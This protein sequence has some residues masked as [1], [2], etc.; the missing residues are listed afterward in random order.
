MND[1]LAPVALFVYNRPEHTLKTLQKLSEADFSQETRLYI[2]ADGAKENATEEQKNR[3]ARVR[4]IIRQKQWCG[5]V[6]IE[7]KEKNAGLAN[8]VRAGI[9]AVAEKHGKVIVLEDDLAVSRGFLRYMN[10]ALKHYENEERVWGISGFGHPCSDYSHQEMTFFLP[11]PCSWGWATW[12]RTLKKFND[13]GTEELKKAVSEGKIEREKYN[14]G[15]Y[16]FFEI[17]EA[18]LAGKIDSW[19]ALFHAQMY[20]ADGLFLFPKFSLVNNIGFDAQGTHTHEDDFFSKTP[21]S[22]S[23]PAEKIAVRL[24]EAT[25]LT[26]KAFRK[27]FGKK[28]IWQRALRKIGKLLK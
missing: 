24:S 15:E 21:I 11:I 9:S 28:T 6:F 5:E 26:E 18:Q 17:L 16:Y 22:E 13:F 1:N 23:I 14:F 27:H 25:R 20:L 7:E 3:T 8:S 19:A 2:F 10:A 4:E 12:Q